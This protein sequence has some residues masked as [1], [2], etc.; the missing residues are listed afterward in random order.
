VVHIELTPR[1]GGYSARIMRC[2]VI[3]SPSR[4]LASAAE[5]LAEIQE[6]Q[7]NAMRPGAL[8]AE[9]DAILRDGVLSAGL[10]DSYDNITG[11][12]LGLYAPAGP[13]T[14][15]FTRIFHPQADWRL[16]ANMVFH[17]YA[18]ASG[19]S[20]SETVLVT[21]RGPERLTKL[22]RALIENGRAT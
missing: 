19:A 18:S 11:Y 8:A 5:R 6:R 16:K 15:D 22:P 14:S 1:V 21:E 3:G 17:M 2:A 10:R 7:I 4:A 12:T 13:R 20:F 9:V